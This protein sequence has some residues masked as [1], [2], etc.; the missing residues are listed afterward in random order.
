MSERYLARHPCSSLDKSHG[1]CKWFQAKCTE[2]LP[3]P[4][5]PAS[6]LQ[7]AREQRQGEVAHTSLAS[8][9]ISPKNQSCAGFPNVFYDHEPQ[10]RSFESKTKRCIMYVRRHTLHTYTRCTHKSAYQEATA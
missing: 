5:A 7:S 2:E 10:A 8:F 3:I 1:G 6:K 4:E 9:M